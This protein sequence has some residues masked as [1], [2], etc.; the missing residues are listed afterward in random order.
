MKVIA[1]TLTV[2]EGAG[3]PLLF[4]AGAHVPHEGVRVEGGR[5][6]HL[7]VQPAGHPVQPV[8]TEVRTQPAGGYLQRG[9]H[10]GLR[11]NANSKKKKKKKKKKLNL[12]L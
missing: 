11:E 10:L 4:A 7:L 5:G 9:G 8:E 6:Q 1:I 2:G 12:T 3:V